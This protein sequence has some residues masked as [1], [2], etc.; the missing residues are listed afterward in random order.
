MT[1]K[2]NSPI[3]YIEPFNWEYFFN[4]L[5]S[6][7]KKFLNLNDIQQ[8]MFKIENQSLK[9][10][11]QEIIDK[12]K[13]Y[14]VISLPF[15]TENQQIISIEIGINISNI[16]EY[17]NQNIVYNYYPLS[18]SNF[19]NRQ[20]LLLNDFYLDDP[21][22]VW[23]N[24]I[25]KFNILDGNHRVQYAKKMGYQYINAYIFDDEMLN[26]SNFFCDLYSYYIFKLWIF[27]NN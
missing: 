23:Y 13:N 8:I 6:S 19:M 5:I 18:L 16:S 2:Y 11:S 1:I 10:F 25:F 4:Q 9:Q 26:H 21:I 27:L 12:E 17:I 20:S 7:K 22:I 15:Q 3:H 14:Y 24:H